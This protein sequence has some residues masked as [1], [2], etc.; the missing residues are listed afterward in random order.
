MFKPCCN[1]FKV[2]FEACGACVISY[3]LLVNCA[4][5]HVSLIVIRYPLIGVRASHESLFL[6]RYS[7]L[8][9]R[10]V[11]LDNRSLITDN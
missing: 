7:M 6:R 2:F 11:P 10:V 5:A 3:K 4:C 8:C 9:P 1:G